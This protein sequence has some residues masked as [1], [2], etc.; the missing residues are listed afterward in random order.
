MK[1]RSM[2][3][4]MPRA[5]GITIV[6]DSTADRIRG[7]RETTL[8]WRQLLWEFADG[9][10]LNKNML[11]TMECFDIIKISINDC[12]A[13]SPEDQRIIRR[14]IG[15]MAKRSHVI[16]I[17]CP[18]VGIGNDHGEQIPLL[19]KLHADTLREEV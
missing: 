18:G 1:E 12:D 2:E 9:E 13:I 5:S 8:L 19:A 3:Q 4:I 7:E 6:E 10:R 11:R 15:Q 16:L 14:V 17:V